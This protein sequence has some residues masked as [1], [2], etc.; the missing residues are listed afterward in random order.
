MILHLPL[1]LC[2]NDNNLARLHNSQISRPDQPL[3]SLRSVSINKPIPSF[4]ETVN[5]LQRLSS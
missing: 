5:N 3:M 1:S 4:P 2:S